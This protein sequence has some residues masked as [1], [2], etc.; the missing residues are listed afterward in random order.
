MTL[1]PVPSDSLEKAIAREPRRPLKILPG[2]ENILVPASTL[3]E[4]NF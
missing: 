2:L 4:I 1:C 3:L